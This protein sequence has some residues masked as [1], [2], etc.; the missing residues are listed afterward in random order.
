MK[1]KS[2]VLSIVSAFLVSCSIPQSSSEVVNKSKDIGSLC[3]D[4][5]P[6][7]VNQRLDSYMVSCYRPFQSATYA[8]GMII[9]MTI[10]QEVVK[11]RLPYGNRYSVKNKLGY[12]FTAEV[13]PNIQGCNT[14]VKAYAYSNGWQ[15]HLKPLDDAVKGNPANCPK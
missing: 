4:L 5:S 6:E 12:A 8:A 3:Y 1:I 9:P 10:H 13:V 15:R 14:F 7:V 2:L 11:E